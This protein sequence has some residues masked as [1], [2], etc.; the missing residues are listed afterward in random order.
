MGEKC[1]CFHWTAQ[2]HIVGIRQG[3]ESVLRPSQGDGS[4]GQTGDGSSQRGHG[5]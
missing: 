3:R 5:W 1:K 2:T 4:P